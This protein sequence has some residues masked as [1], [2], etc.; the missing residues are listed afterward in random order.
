MI[1]FTD[2]Q[3]DPTAQTNKHLPHLEDLILFDGV[4]GLR[5][6]TWLLSDLGFLLDGGRPPLHISVKWDGAPAVIF[7][8]DPADGR[9]FV[10]TKSALNKTRLLAH[11]HE[12]IDALF[13]NPGVAK[14][15]HVL[16]DELPALH[17]TSILQGDV[18]F[19]PDTY[20][21]A[22]IGGNYMFRPNT[23]MYAVPTESEMGQRI[24]N[25]VVGIV[26]HTV[27][28]PGWSASPLTA[29]AYASLK[30]TSR[31]VALD[32]TYDEPARWTED[33]RADYL[34]ALQDLKTAS[35]RDWT[36][37]FDKLHPVRKELSLYL[38][39]TIREGSS[40]SVFGFMHFS[41]Q[42][43]KPRALGAFDFAHHGHQLAHWFALH[44]ALAHAKTLI[45]RKLAS[46]S[47]VTAYVPTDTGYEQTAPE[48]FVVTAH[49]GQMVKL[50]DRRVFSRLNFTVRRSWQ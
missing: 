31:V 39:H 36:D 7:G 38:N 29:L 46:T 4:E 44:K 37:F 42:R 2:F 34:L 23:L 1:S 49:N 26:L 5:F 48:G 11:T 45:V 8:P 35:D 19:T 30:Q 43:A 14:V 21:E 27:Y 13:V 24:Q 15:L 40:P 6:A 17:P 3:R 41:K 50:V 32:A 9:F 22:E 28:S 10:S 47:K 18:L 16:L 25:A 12:E 33:E 20:V